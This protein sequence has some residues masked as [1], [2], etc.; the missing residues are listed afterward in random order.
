M[1]YF[2]AAGSTVAFV[3]ASGTDPG[4]IRAVNAD[5]S[6]ERILHDPN[7][8]LK[9]KVLGDTRELRIEVDGVAADGWAILP[10]GYSK[11]TKLP[12]LL[13]IH[14]GPHS[15]YGWSFQLSEQVLAAAGYAVVFC[16]PPGSQSYTEEFARAA[17]GRWGDADLP[18]F[19]KT[20]D[21]AIDAGFADPDRLGVTGGSYGGFSTLWAVTHTN[22]FKAAVAEVPVSLLE[23][24]YG[25]SDIGWSFTSPELGAEPW[26]DPDAYRRR[27]PALMLERVTTPLRLIANLSDIRTPLEQAE[28]VYVRLK[29]M[30]KVVDLVLF[31][32]E[33]HRLPVIGKPW[34]R[35]RRVRA[36]Q[37]WFDRYLKTRD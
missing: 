22:R 13:V 7:P 3:T 37:E 24:F 14:G 23:S 16:N 12:T 10:P 25:S 36:L 30:G 15:A 8:W 9:N 27:S 26:E 20:V 35:V 18:F 11:G 4:T 28:Q 34:N 33:S 17:L 32:G 19:L 29:K 5:G 1:P 2:S 6:G 21:A 31:H